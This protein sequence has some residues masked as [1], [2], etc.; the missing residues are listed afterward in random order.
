MNTRTS[1]CSVA[2]ALLCLLALLGCQRRPAAAPIDADVSLAVAGFTQPA[3]DKAA[4]SGYVPNNSAE[5]EPATM[6]KLDAYLIKNLSE[7]TRRSFA[8]PAQ[9]RKCMPET[10][11][12]ISSSFHGAL[13]YYIQVGVCLGVDYLVVPQLLFWHELEGG[14]AGTRDPAS[15]MLDIYVLD[16]AEHGVAA[17][18]RFDE[19]QVSLA[20]NVLTFDKFVQRGGK[21]LT[22]AQLAEWGI[23]DGLR[24]LGLK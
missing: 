9:A 14:P 17:R 10:E 22:A 13:D 1:V 3:T 2:L 4:L 8:G 7:Q 24:V 20:E 5:V 16:I 21:W 6:A 11:S 23:N 15:V 18:Y 12:A 19:T